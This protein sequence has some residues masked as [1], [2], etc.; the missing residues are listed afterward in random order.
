MA[1]FVPGA[2]LILSF[3]VFLFDFTSNPNPK[4]NHLVEFVS[5]CWTAGVSSQVAFT[6]LAA[7]AGMVIH[8]L[9]WAV[10]GYY[11]SVY[12]EH[13]VYSTWWARHLSPIGYILIGPILALWELVV[14]LCL[15]WNLANISVDENVTEVSK[16]K[17]P[18]FTFLQDFYLHFAQFFAHTAYALIFSTIALSALSWHHDILNNFALVLAGIYPLSGLLYLLSRIQF[19]SLFQAEMQLASNDGENQPGS[20]S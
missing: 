16:D 6:V 1:Q 17:M 12:S 20:S 4:I 5:T 14:F 2:I 15:G 10:L 7:I 18:A 19:F 13:G 3:T 8:G 9:N 11:E